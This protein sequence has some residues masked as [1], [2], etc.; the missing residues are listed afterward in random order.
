M[1]VDPH[2]V[3]ISSSS[4]KLIANSR[5]RRIVAM[6]LPRWAEPDPATLTASRGI[7]LHIMDAPVRIDGAGRSESITVERIRHL[8]NGA[9]EGTGHVESYPVGQVYGA[10]GHA[11]AR[12]AAVPFDTDRGRIPN[13]QGRIVQ[14]DG[15]P[16][17]GLSVSGWIERGPLGLIGSTESDSQESVRDLVADVEHLARPGRAE[18]DPLPELLDEAG[19]PYIDWGGWLRGAPHEDALGTER[20]RHRVTVSPRDLVAS[21]A[22]EQRADA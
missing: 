13:Q 4:E 19:L 12:L 20:G 8:P 2:D 17:P 5:Q 11:G 1:I 18:K 22:L 3:I 15:T 21:I 10:V 6:T 9:V 7:R 16:L 14:P